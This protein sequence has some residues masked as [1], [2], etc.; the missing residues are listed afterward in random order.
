M[1]RFIALENVKRFK[2]QLEDCQDEQQRET[3]TLLLAAEE[4]KL[5][6]LKR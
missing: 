5:K 3:L 4:A 2:K 1:D 6:H